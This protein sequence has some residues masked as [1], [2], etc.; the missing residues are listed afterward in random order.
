MTAWSQTAANKLSRL[1]F[2]LTASPPASEVALCGHWQ[3]FPFSRLLILLLV[4]GISPN[5]GPRPPHPTSPPISRILQFNTNGL[6]TSRNELSSYL[7][8]NNIKV[9]CLQE[10]KLR[11]NN[12][13]PSFPGYALL[14]RDRPE[15]G[16]GGVAILVSHDVEFTLVYVDYLAD[17]HLEVLA[18]KIHLRHFSLNIYNVYI[19]PVSSCDPNYAPNLAALFDH[20]DGD[21][22][23]V[24]DFNA[25]SDIW[26]SASNDARRELLVDA[27]EGSD[28]SLLNL[29]F[30]TRIPSSSSPFLERPLRNI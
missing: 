12:P 25:H 9:A 27:V 21:A 28:F 29:D 26:F 7:R 1:P 30:P 13:D 16:G 3:N 6:N 19:P 15:G 14:R 10:T 8:G 11:S 24:G 18:V 20:A 4:A 2:R 5:P 17:P 22:V 23:I